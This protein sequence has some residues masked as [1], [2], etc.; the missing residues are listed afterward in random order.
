MTIKAHIWNSETVSS[1]AYRPTTIGIRNPSEYINDVIVVGPKENAFISA[2]CD[3][4]KEAASKADKRIEKWET[5]K[6]CDISFDDK[7][8]ITM[9]EMK[10]KTEFT[11]DAFPTLSEKTEICLQHI[12][13]HT[14][15]IIEKISIKY[16]ISVLISLQY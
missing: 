12:T 10:Y 15:K 11:F 16:G 7:S 2:N 1:Q 9:H 3:N 6:I 5:T 13:L 4:T 8:I 14:E